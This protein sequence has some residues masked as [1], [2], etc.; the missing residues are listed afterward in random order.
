MGISLGMVEAGSGDFF[1]LFFL[2]CIFWGAIAE[3][4]TGDG[5]FVQ[6][7][8]VIWIIK[9]NI[10]SFLMRKL[11]ICIRALENN[12]RRISFSKPLEHI[13]RGHF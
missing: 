12:K 1:T 9:N 5:S 10:K 6:L 2:R 13:D 11:D 4:D 7:Q 8:A 3:G